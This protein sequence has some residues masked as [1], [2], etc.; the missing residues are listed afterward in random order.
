M[1]KKKIC[2]GFW[3]ISVETLH[4]T[5]FSL[6][7]ITMALLTA[8][9]F[10]LSL[11]PNS[12]TLESAPEESLALVG[13]AL[14][15]NIGTGIPRANEIPVNLPA[16]TLAVQ[17]A[18]TNNTSVSSDFFA[19]HF[20][21][22]SE[23]TEIMNIDMTSYLSLH[24]DKQVA[25][26]NYIVKLEEKIEESSDALASLK[27]LNSQHTALLP[28]IQTEIK[29]TQLRIES[30]YN[31]RDGW[32]IISDLTQIEE[33]RIQEQ[34][35]KNISI[36]ATRIAQEYTVLLASAQ[37]RIIVLRANIAPLVQGIT[38]KLPAS[39]NIQTLKELKIFATEN[40]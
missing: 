32:A 4:W 3:K 7:A 13:V 27:Q 26:E 19:E 37:E 39:I 28:G 23:L 34:E 6:V 21:R 20:L 17:N 8:Y 38:V 5:V 31:N 16:D 1:K 14:A 12:F 2:I 33:L 40:Q 25:L 9:G 22:I 18:L 24:A 30:S 35:H 29:N 11:N 10:S 36:F 15:N